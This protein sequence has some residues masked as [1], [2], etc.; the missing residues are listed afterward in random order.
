MKM[1]LLPVPV[2]LFLAIIACPGKE[3]QLPAPSAAPVL[4]APHPLSIE[5]LRSRKWEPG[6]FTIEKQISRNAGYTSYL[7]SYLSDGNTIYALVNLPAAAKEG[8]KLPV[9]I[10]NHG[11]IAPNEYSTVNSYRNI[12]AYYAAAGFLVIKP[13]YRGHGNSGGITEDAAARTVYYAV[14]VLNLIACL[15]TY[16][17]AD[18][19]RLFMYG[20]SMGGE[21]TLRVLEATT[22]VKAASLWAPV[23]AP[24]PESTL[25]F[26]RRRQTALLEKEQAILGASVKQEDYAA[27]SPLYFTRYITIPLLLHHGTEDES[28]PYAWSVTLA[29]E[30]RKAGVHFTFHTYE[31]ENHNLSRRSYTT[32]AARDVELFRSLIE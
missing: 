1:R 26:H 27:L 2:L 8:K 6:V 21:V 24:F 22:A 29:E 23:S 13:D 9:V 14:D 28:V 3:R 30:L 19:D 16:P 18:T 25:Y 32:V 5:A 17:Y 15:S 10:V 31:K 7:A 4:S 20:H 11:Y 12:S